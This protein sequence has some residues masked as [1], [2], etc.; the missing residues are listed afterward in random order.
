MEIYVVRHT[1]VSIE[2][3]TC[4]GQSDVPLDNDYI[5]D[6]IKVKNR[7]PHDFDKVFSSPLKRCCLLAESISTLEI[8]YHDSL[9]EMNFGDWENKTWDTIDQK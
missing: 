8:E 1:K 3:G 5:K 4:Y 7:L 6:I 2:K 9:M